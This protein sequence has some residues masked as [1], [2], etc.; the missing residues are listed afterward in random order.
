MVGDG[1]LGLCA[2]VLPAAGSGFDGLGS[3]VFAGIELSQ[4]IQH[5]AMVSA[6]S[7]KLGALV[8]GHGFLWIDLLRYAAGIALAAVL[9]VAIIFWKGRNIDRSTEL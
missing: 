8:L 3:W 5:P 4:L 7:T 6:R 2:G 1:V 9:D